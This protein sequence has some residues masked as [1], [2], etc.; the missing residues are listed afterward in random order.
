MSKRIRAGVAGVGAMG[1][2]HA[3]VLAELESADLT[4]IYDVDQARAQELATLYGAQ[5]VSSLEEFASLVDA[6][7]VA[8]PTVFHR[9]V[10]GYLLEQG[11]HV[12][13]EKPLSESLQEAQELME[14]ADARQLVLQVGHIE[15]FNPV[16]QQLEDRIKLPRFIEATRLSPFPNRSID[17]GVTL[18]LMIHD[19]EIILHLV[20]GSAVVSIDAVGVPVLTRREDIANARLRFANGCVANVTASRVSDKKMRKIQ[21]FHTEGYISLDYQEQAGHAYR[22]EGM[23]IVREEVPVEKDEPLKLELA[24]FIDCAS[25]GGKPVVGGHQGTE[26]LRLAVLIMKAMEQNSTMTLPL[27]PTPLP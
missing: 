17:I 9:E 11:K 14:L 20:G 15:R 13:V 1:K 4:A 23:A 16:M 5:A 18:D 3:R 19:L 27:P 10:A 2:N 21:V 25:R 8:V 7:A 12:L 6:V 26:A 24:S 22:R